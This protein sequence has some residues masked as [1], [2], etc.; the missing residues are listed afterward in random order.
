MATQTRT[1]T[2]RTH[3]SAR[4]IAAEREAKRRKLLIAGSVAAAAVLALVLILLNLPNSE[5]DDLPAVVAAAQPYPDVPSEGRV[6]GDPNAPVTV[7]EYGDY[8]CPG[9]AQFASD[10]EPRLVADYVATGLVRFEFRDYAFLDDRAG[11]SESDDAA[12]A[13][14]AAAAQGAFWAFHATLYGNQ[15]GENEGAFTEE[16]LI[17]MAE[18]LGLD[19]PLFRAAL[20]DDATGRTVAAMTEEARGLGLPGTP[21]FTINGKA[22]D[23]QGY[24]SVATAIDAELA[25]LGVE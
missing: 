4:R 17:A 8:Q 9:C 5:G 19:M 20:D 24:D 25:A 21:S 15:H 3:R 22:I 18:A 13:A 10:M 12:A 11:G 14:E 2:R 16:R 1:A 7:V 23:Y 6:L